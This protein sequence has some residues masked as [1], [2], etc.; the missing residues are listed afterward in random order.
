MTSSVLKDT[1][2]D[3]SQSS[4]DGQISPR[5]GLPGRLTLGF[6]SLVTSHCP[7]YDGS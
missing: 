7:F 3:F 1:V 4:K 6:L 5:V 2:S